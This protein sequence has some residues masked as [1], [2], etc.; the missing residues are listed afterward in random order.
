M[1]TLRPYPSV[2]WNYNLRYKLRN[3]TLSQPHRGFHSTPQPQFIEPVIS[4]THYVLETLHTTTPLPW[5]GVLPLTAFLVRATFT[6]PLAIYSRRVQQRQ[7][8]LR[9]VLLAWRDQIRHRTLR[10]WGATGRKNCESRITKAIRLKQ[11]ELYK[12]WSC[13]RWK[14][15]LPLAQLPVWLVVVETIRRMCG[16]HKGLLGLIFSTREEIPSSNIPNL[17]APT[18]VLTTQTQNLGDFLGSIEAGNLKELVTIEPSFAQ[19][20]ALWFQDLL[21]PDPLLILPFVLSGSLFMNLYLGTRDVRTKKLSV[22]Q[23]RWMNTLKIFALAIGPMTLQVPSA[24]LVYWIS[25]SFFA[26]GQNVL[27]DKF[28]PLAPGLNTEKKESTE[29]TVDGQKKD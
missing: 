2:S 1:P 10:E 9:Y 15:F 7:L 25:S 24:I 6:A 23:R 12:R 18:G 8:A 21:V 14:L 22:Y 11:S 29:K 4:A 27:L 28:L 13:E 3:S 17:E 26:L 16:T 19:E 20:G 5:V